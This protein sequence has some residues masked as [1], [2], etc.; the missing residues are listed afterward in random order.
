MPVKFIDRLNSS[1]THDI[2]KIDNYSIY[3]GLGNNYNYCEQVV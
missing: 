1:V 3:R 2:A